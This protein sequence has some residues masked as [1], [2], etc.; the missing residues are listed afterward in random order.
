MILHLP[1]PKTA[2]QWCESQR[3]D[4]RS[5]GYVPTM[6]ALHEGHLSLIRRSL[7]EN[8]ATCVSIFVNPLQFDDPEDLKRYP[9]DLRQDIEMLDAIGCDM[10]FVGELH[11]FFPGTGSSDNIE[12]EPAGPAGAGLEGDHRPGHLDGVRTIVSRLFQTVGP[13]RAYFGEK[14]FQQTLVVRALAKELGYPQIVVCPVSRT[15][16]GLARSSRNVL[17][18]DDEREQ[19][20]V[21]YR[22]LVTARQRWDNGERDAGRLQEAMQS[23]LLGSE[24]DGLE[25]EY[26]EIRDPD[27]WTADMPQG[28]LPRA[29]ALIALR[30]GRVRL[31]D[32]MRLDRSS[33]RAMTPGIDQ[34][35]RQAVGR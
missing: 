21:I 10:V 23:V 4:G 20:S 6:G 17:L 34:D 5:I 2:Q 12:L 15:V 14:D 7:I 25:L 28:Q 18:T 19:A 30:L 35:H 32:N 26:A 16:T 29:Q 9:N 27:N 11:E 24:I 33:P 22:A 8:D 31:I 1:D 13:C 3:W